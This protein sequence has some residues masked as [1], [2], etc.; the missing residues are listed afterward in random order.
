[1]ASVRLSGA[2]SVI[3]DSQG[4]TQ[5]LDISNAA[6]DGAGGNDLLR[7]GSGNDFLFGGI[8]NDRLFGGDGDDF[9]LADWPMM[10]S[11]AAAGMT[12]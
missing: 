4:A 9:L 1:M 12:M 10:N 6:S 11:M 5:V 3:I 8:G 7:G 2:L